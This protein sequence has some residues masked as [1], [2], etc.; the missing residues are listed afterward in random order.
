MRNIAGGLLLLGVS[1]SIL[2]DFGAQS[3]FLI[4]IAPPHR[5]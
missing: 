1:S 5:K 2:G 4:M 3:A